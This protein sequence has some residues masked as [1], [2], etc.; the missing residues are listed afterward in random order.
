M[1]KLEGNTATW[2]GVDPVKVSHVGAFEPGVAVKNLNE[3]QVQYLIKT[4]L[5]VQ[6]NEADEGVK[7]E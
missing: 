4:G 5:V 2:T 6:D 1:F 3:E 7:D